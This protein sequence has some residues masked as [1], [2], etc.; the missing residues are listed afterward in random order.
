MTKATD[1]PLRRMVN[2]ASLG[3]LVVEVTV[4]TVR[5]RPPRVRVASAIVELPWGSLY[6]HGLI[7]ADN[8]RRKARRKR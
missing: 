3:P 4:R 1:T 5:I 7:L 6:T 8:G 2:G